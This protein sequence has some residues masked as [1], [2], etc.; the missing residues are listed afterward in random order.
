MTAAP[1]NKPYVATVQGRW[2]T[3]SYFDKDFYIGQ[4]FAH[5]GEFSPDETEFVIK[6]AEKAGKDKLVLDIGANIGAIAQALEFSGFTV[7]GFEP[8][9]EVHELLKMNMKGKAHNVA[10][11][12][13]AGFTTMPN[14]DYAQVNN[15]GGISIN[16]ASKSR[17]AIKVEVRTLDSYNFQ[18]VGL[19]KIDVEGFE[20]EVL[21]GATETI[22]RCSPIMYIEDD[23]VEKSDA[24]HKYLKE[25]GYRFERHNPPLFRPDNFFRK[26]DNIWDRQFVSKNLVCFK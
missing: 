26:P 25:L 13:R 10:L 20:E 3:V 15:Y 14:F 7:E 19:M 9:P 11:A 2:G 8:Q 12:S 4:S 1:A 16:T 18:N 6:L 24:L 22:K 23:R 5:Y 21:R 17:G